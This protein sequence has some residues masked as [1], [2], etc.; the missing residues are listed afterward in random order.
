MFV[1]EKS[2]QFFGCSILTNG[3][4]ESDSSKLDLL[5]IDHESESSFYHPQKK[6]SEPIIN[7]TYNSCNKALIKKK[8]NLDV[9][10][11]VSYDHRRNGS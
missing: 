9:S 6:Y 1:D 4:Y 5:G 8:G 11:D 3:T 7:S 10:S 2:N